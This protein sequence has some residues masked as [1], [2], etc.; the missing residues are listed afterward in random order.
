M[1]RSICPLPHS[2]P[3]PR[4]V[5]LASVAVAPQAADI[6]GWLLVQDIQTE[7]TGAL[8]NLYN[9]KFDRA[10]KQFRS[11]R[12]RYLQHPLPYFLMALST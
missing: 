2:L 4:L 6:Q 3:I 5:A 10:E 7:L 8:H 1:P 9:F 12:R 11:L